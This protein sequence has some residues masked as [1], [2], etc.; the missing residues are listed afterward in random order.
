[1]HGCGLVGIPSSS[2]YEPG[3]ET[4]PVAG[5]ASCRSDAIFTRLPVIGNQDPAPRA[6]R[7]VHRLNLN[8]LD[9]TMG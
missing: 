9:E 6:V 3:S 4:L 2:S 8:H 7:S 1:M 5:S